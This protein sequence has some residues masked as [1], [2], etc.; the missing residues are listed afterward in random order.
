MT[1]P[2]NKLE[3]NEKAD[4]GTS[5]QRDKADK[6][7]SKRKEPTSEDDLFVTKTIYPDAEAVFTAR[8]KP[9]DALRENCIVVLDTNVLLVPFGVSKQSLDQLRKTY[10]A[11]AD[12][13]RLVVPAHTAREFAKNRTSK[14]AELYQ[15]LYRRKGLVPI[16]PRN[17][18]LLEGSKDYQRVLEVEGKINALAKD[19]ND[20]IEKALANIA[21]WRWNDPVSDMY[22]E[23]FAK[24]VIHE[25]NIS[26]EELS[27]DWERRVHHKVPPGYKDGG[28]DQN[29]GGDLI[30]WHTILDIGRTRQKSVLFVSGETKPDWWHRVEGRP[31][32][33]RYELVDEF[34]R[35]SAGESFHMAEL[36]HLMDMF[37]AAPQVIEEIRKEEVVL[38]APTL[39]FGVEQVSPGRHSFRYMLQRGF[40]AESAVGRWLAARSPVNVERTSDDFGV[41]YRVPGPGGDNWVIVKYIGDRVNNIRSRIVDVLSQSSKVK[42]R[43]VNGRV[44]VVLVA[45]N[46]DI[47]AKALSV[48]RQS[49][50]E[51]TAPWLTV[52][53][54]TLSGEGAFKEKVAASGMVL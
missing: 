7:K 21:A 35:S 18:P 13:G 28:K 44:M 50:A 19:Y 27:I 17:Y 45:E 6:S 3:Q 22:A 8:L 25:V 40:E 24:G 39:E 41:D 48:V 51:S 26:P 30:V 54:G 12:Q 37:G 9:L 5:E 32:Y 15:F 47:A 42:S 14:L 1:E 43:Y 49:V 33:P 2:K 53:V 10:K 34:R 52:V 29:A 16:A 31:L 20:A 46:E 4:A 23:V 36:S 38:A 11:L